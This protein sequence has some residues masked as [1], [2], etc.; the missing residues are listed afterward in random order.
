V[1]LLAVRAARAVAALA[2]RGEV[3]PEDAAMAGRLVLAPRATML[4]QTAPQAGTEDTPADPP[5]SAHPNEPTPSEA[6][7]SADDPEQSPGQDEP[8]DR[9]EGPQPLGETPLQDVVLEAAQA[10]IPAG[11]LA[12]LRVGQAPRGSG[13]G[14]AGRAGVLR[15]GGARGRPCGVRSGPP[16]GQ[17]RL[18][19]METLRTAAPWQRLRGR[20][21][22]HDTR[23]RI[24]PGDFRVT[25][26]Q[27]RTRTLTIFAVDASGSSALNRLAE[28]KGAV[29]LLLADCYVRRDQV[30]V[31]T[32][33]G[34]VAELLLPPTR[35]LVRAKRQLAGLPGGGGTPL[36]AALDTALIVANQARR[37]GESPL[38]VLLTDGRANVARNGSGGREAAH[39]DALLAARRLRQAGVASLFV[40]TSPRPNGLAETLAAAMNAQY[41]PLPFADARSLSRVVSA[42]AATGVR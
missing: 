32:F 23:V 38:L 7:D 10:A 26:Y 40:D 17:S 12:Q 8:P 31:I 18:N 41:I 4:P 22:E 37:R 42:A 36:A 16:R 21:L 35:S 11:L 28:A 33:R 1:S 20:V 30:A 15:S 24:D 25:Q 3:L 27:E 29:E 13:A 14:P 2:G 34:R 9:D 5:P 19:I 39:A 6:R